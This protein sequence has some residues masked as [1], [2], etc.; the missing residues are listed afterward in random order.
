MASTKPVSVGDRVRSYDF[1]QTDPPAFV[2]GRVVHADSQFVTILVERDVWGF[3]EITDAA[4]RVGYDVTVPQNGR[5]TLS[6]PDTC[7]IEVL[8]DVCV[9]GTSGQVNRGVS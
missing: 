6:G 7:R 5:P 1:G 3:E 8:G 4:S 9:R 2:E